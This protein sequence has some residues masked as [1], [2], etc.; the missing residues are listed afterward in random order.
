MG[1]GTIFLKDALSEDVENMKMS[2]R[3]DRFNLMTYF[4]R[5]QG[6][7][8]EGDDVDWPDYVILARFIH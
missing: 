2:I 4:N 1:N 7:F 3:A 5:E 8:E 6:R